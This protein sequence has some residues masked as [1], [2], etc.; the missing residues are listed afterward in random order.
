MGLF[1]REHLEEKTDLEKALQGIPFADKLQFTFNNTGDVKNEQTKPPVYLLPVDSHA[2]I[3]YGSFILEEGLSEAPFGFLRQSSFL[4]KQYYRPNLT[5][6]LVVENKA[7]GVIYLPLKLTSAVIGIGRNDPTA[8]W[9][10]HEGSPFPVLG[11]DGREGVYPLMMVAEEESG[12]SCKG[13]YLDK[14][15]QLLFYDHLS[16]IRQPD[17][18]IKEFLKGL[19]GKAFMQVSVLAPT[20]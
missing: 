11:V 15:K 14:E 5:G 10:A 16:K 12:L 3:V 7:K 4:S 13:L 18:A 1:T 20:R 8:G 17:S 6:G 2:G 19:S 9:V